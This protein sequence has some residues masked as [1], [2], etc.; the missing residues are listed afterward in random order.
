MAAA[1]VFCLFPAAVFPEGAKHTDVRK[2]C[3]R[4]MKGEFLALL[5]ENAKA[6]G[7]K[8]EGREEKKKTRAEA[9]AAD[10]KRCAL[11]DTLAGEAEDEHE[12]EEAREESAS[13]FARAERRAIWLSASCI[14]MEKHSR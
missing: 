1:I 10:L 13:A 11:G 8:A 5:E 3:A 2:N 9:V 12:A 4:F 7:A 6:Q 14:S